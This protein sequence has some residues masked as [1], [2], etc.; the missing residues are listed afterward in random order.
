VTVVKV[1][2]IGALS[3]HTLTAV[4]THEAHLSK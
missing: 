4:G 3:Y 2:L 1:R